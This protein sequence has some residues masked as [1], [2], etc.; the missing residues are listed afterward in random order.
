MIDP[1]AH[2]HINLVG[3]VTMLG[4]AVTYYLL[5]KLTGRAIYSWRMVE[6]SFWWTTIGVFSFYTALMIFGT[7]EGWFWLHDPVVVPK[8]HRFYG[9]VISIAAS[10]LA[11][12]FWIYFANVL[13]SLR[14]R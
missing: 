7:V 14:R 1:L 10:V 3:G 9:P 6:H 8:I 5:P 11:I 12:G 13:L 2:A 4:M